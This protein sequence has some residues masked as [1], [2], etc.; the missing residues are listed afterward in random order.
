MLLL[1]PSAFFLIG[2]MIW[3]VR[4]FRQDQVEKAEFNIMPAAQANAVHL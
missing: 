2:F 3:I 4:Y 1:P